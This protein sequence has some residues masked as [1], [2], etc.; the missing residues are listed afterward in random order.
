MRVYFA[1]PSHIHNRPLQTDDDMKRFLLGLAAFLFLSLLVAFPE[2]CV[3]GAKSGLM[4]WFQIIIP[5]LLPFLIVSSL[6]VELDFVEGICRLCHPILGRLLRISPHGCYPIVIGLLSGYPVGAKVCGDL[7]RGGKLKPSEGEFILPF[8]NSASPMFL[9]GYL[10]TEKLRITGIGRYAP[11]LLLFLTGLGAS[12]LFRSLAA[13][14]TGRLSKRGALR[15]A[16]ILPHPSYDAPITHDNSLTRLM[17]QTIMGSFEVLTKVGGYIILF[18]I[19]GHV[20]LQIPLLPTIPK[21]LLVGGLEI[22]T[23]IHA[24]GEAALPRVQKII[25]CCSITAFG[26]LSALAQTKSVMESTGLSLTRYSLCK[27]SIAFLTAILLFF[28]L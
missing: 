21:L 26:G 18:S 5:N 25:L 4:L 12:L 20:I 22:T 6:I 8:C 3:Q 10:A 17:D 28:L 16:Q 9:I 11:W 14:R 13:I 19:L 23:G 7:I 15:A 24:I 27:L 2:P 1:F